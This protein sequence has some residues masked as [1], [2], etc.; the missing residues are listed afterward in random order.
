MLNA[1]TIA[2]LKNNEKFA[3]AVGELYTDANGLEYQLKRYADIYSV[4]AAKYSSDVLFFSSP[5][6]IELCGNHTDHNNGKVLCASISVD[7]VACV[8][9]VIS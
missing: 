1:E 4:H 3:K 9:P 5:G 7:T 6:R 8:T 2:N